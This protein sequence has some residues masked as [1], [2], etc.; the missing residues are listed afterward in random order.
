MGIFDFLSGTKSAIAISF[1]DDA[2]RV[3]SVA[4]THNKTD[5]VYFAEQVLPQ[6]V[7]ERSVIA[8]SR[9][10]Q[11]ALRGLKKSCRINAPIHLLVPEDRVVSF[12]TKVIL[13]RS[14]QMAVL[15]EDHL[16][17]YVMLHHGEIPSDDSVCE[18]EVTHVSDN[19]VEVSAVVMQKSML[20]SYVELF[21]EVGLTVL[22]C[23]A[24]SYVFAKHHA[25]KHPERASVVISLQEEGSVIVISH[26]G[27]AYQSQYVPIGGRD[28]VRIMRDYVAMEYGDARSALF[29]HG[30]L[31]THPDKNVYKA[32]TDAL[33]PVGN[34]ADNMATRFLD[35]SHVPQDAV[36]YLMGPYATLPGIEEYFSRI[37]RM[38]AL[39][40]TP[41]HLFATHADGAM[42][43]VPVIHLRD[44]LHFAPVIFCAYE[45][46]SRV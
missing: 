23:N 30:M 11:E 8:D 38:S 4:K 13:D 26:N 40:A 15:I 29:K 27:K 17:A 9:A 36:V 6:G 41:H 33:A 25:P 22:T 44:F 46:T 24:P 19:V 18:Y 5:I 28:L 39:K 45:Y 10:F 35:E 1:H 43:E 3:A 7:V 32:L 14:V 37:T 42:N 34:E 20:R 21:A 31:S 2:I 16:K 12:T